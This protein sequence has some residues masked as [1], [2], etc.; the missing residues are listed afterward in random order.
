MAKKMNI[1]SKRI[2]Y[3]AMFSAL[4]LLLAYFTSLFLGPQLRGSD[5][6]LIRATLMVLL[7]ARLRT[8]GGPILMGL[9]SGM[10][11][12]GI[13]API[14]FFYLPG[15]LAAGLVYDASLNMGNYAEA[16]QSRKRVILASA[17]SGLSESIIVT[18]GFFII[19][20]PF[21]EISTR[22][23]LGGLN[24]GIAGIWLY[25]I[26]K[27]GLMSII[28]AIIALSLIPRLKR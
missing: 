18:A 22:L 20:F 7:A 11:L 13:P 1:G 25:S 27:N 19:G 23:S 2:S 10:L 3:A 14:S 12:L 26:G 9:I 17:L 16:T 24:P 4:Y 8:P 28:G 21:Q 6:H 15:S 5:A